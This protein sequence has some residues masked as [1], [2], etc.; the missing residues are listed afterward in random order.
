MTNPNHRLPLTG[1]SPV[2]ERDSFVAYVARDLEQDGTGL[3]DPATLNPVR[4]LNSDNYGPGAGPERQ[5]THMELFLAARYSMKGVSVVLSRDEGLS[6]DLKKENL[7]TIREHSYK[8]HGQRLNRWGAV[9][10]YGASKD[11]FEAS[12]QKI[13]DKIDGSEELA[14]I[15]LS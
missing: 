1:L 11:E 7:D 10:I 13:I 15:H 3:Q 8:S 14:S 5:L 4:I 6:K 2:P 9:I 12:M